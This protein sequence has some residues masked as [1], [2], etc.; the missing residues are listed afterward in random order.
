LQESVHKLLAEVKKKLKLGKKDSDEECNDELV[1][2]PQGRK[3]PRKG[4]SMKSQ[5]SKVEKLIGEM[6]KD[7]Q[8]IF[9]VELDRGQG[10]VW[11]SNFS[12]LDLSL[13]H[14][15]LTESQANV[16][17][18]EYAS[19]HPEVSYWGSFLGYIPPKGE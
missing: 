18:R 1:D 11:A 10:E 8:Y 2:C 16:A 15:A 5:N 9:L 17:M 7:P 12:A 6:L 4:D 3:Q 19:S 14:G 13:S